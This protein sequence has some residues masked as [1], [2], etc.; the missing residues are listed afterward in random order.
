MTIASIIHARKGTSHAWKVQTEYNKLT[1]SAYTLRHYGTVMLV[2][3]DTPEGTRIVDW[4]TGHGS[5][6]DQNGLNTAF[7]VLGLHYRMDRDYRG[8]GARF[9]HLI[10][11]TNYYDCKCNQDSVSDQMWRNSDGF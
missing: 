10:C 5:V 3:I 11:G 7:R 9:T 2:W 1:E 4:S 8:G 6:S